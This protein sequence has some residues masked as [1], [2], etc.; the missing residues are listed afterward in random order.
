MQELCRPEFFPRLMERTF[1]E[2]WSRQESGLLGAVR[3]TVK[4]LHFMPKVA[5]SWQREL[6][7]SQD[8]GLGWPLLQV[9]VA[10]P[11]ASLQGVAVACVLKED[12]LN[13]WAVADIQSG[14]KGKA[15]FFFFLAIESV[16]PP[17]GLGV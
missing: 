12:G 4:N 9:R 10:P 17:D 11:K 16:G 15:V 6:P 3:A 7:G 8:S 13:T 14:G 2:E 5:E 1:G